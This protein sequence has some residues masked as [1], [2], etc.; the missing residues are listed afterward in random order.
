M[1]KSK[2]GQPSDR[3]QFETF[4]D[5][6]VKIDKEGKEGKEEKFV[7]TEAQRI[8]ANYLWGNETTNLYKIK[9][10]LKKD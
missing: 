3:F 4:R 6:K 10:K 7:L 1:K 5:R 2:S 9:A 8:K